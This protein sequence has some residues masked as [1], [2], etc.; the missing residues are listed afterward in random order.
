MPAPS[1]EALRHAFDR[2]F[3]LPLA[4]GTR[5]TLDF[6]AVRVAG[7][8]YA[9]ARDEL[10]G[11][12]VELRVTPVPSPD[13]A[14][15][16]LVGVRGGLVAVFDLGVL[17]G[18]RPCATP[19]RWL[20]LGRRDVRFALCFDELEGY[21]SVPRAALRSMEARRDAFVE[22]ALAE[23]GGLRPLV[24]IGKIL[25]L[26]NERTGRTRSEKGV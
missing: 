6:L 25:Q 15:V 4:E 5:D 24:N 7:R 11:V 17:V 18:A 9:L 12:A 14:L 21:R 26:L 2:S 1:A 20:A 19:A 13:P 23:N 8:A 10:G 3:A 22:Q 16:G